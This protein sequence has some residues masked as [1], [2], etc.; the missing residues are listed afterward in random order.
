MFINPKSKK[1]RTKKNK[2]KDKKT[3]KTNKKTNPQDF[4]SF[5][6]YLSHTIVLISF[7]LQHTLQGPKCAAF[8]GCQSGT[9]FVKVGRVFIS[10]KNYSIKCI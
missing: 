6:S 8:S 5:D 1:K 3:N 10:L 2:N 7:F 9:I 4:D